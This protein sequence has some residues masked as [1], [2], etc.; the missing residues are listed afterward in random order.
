MKISPNGY[1]TGSITVLK[2]R[3]NC[4]IVLRGSHDFDREMG[5]FEDRS[6]AELQEHYDFEERAYNEDH[7]D[8]GAEYERRG[9]P[10]E[11]EFESESEEEECV[12]A[13]GG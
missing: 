12:G 10:N 11:M 5:L 1:T 2:L 8:F 13:V 3:K 6:P 7:T 9:L 4:R